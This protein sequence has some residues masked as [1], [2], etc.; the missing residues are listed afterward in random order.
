MENYLRVVSD[1]DR[2]IKEVDGFLE[3]E[4]RTLINCGRSIITVVLV[5]GKR[6]SL[7]PG[8]GMDLVVTSE[9][10]FQRPG[11]LQRMRLFLQRKFR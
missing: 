1:A 2:E 11:V 3:S 7:S 5:G 6:V 9:G 10:G 4:V 8:D